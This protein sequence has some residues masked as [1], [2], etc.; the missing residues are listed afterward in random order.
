VCGCIRKCVCVCVCVRESDIMFG[1]CSS[2]VQYQQSIFE[3]KY[4]C[5]F[6]GH[7]ALILHLCVWVY[8]ENGVCVCVCVCVYVCE[9]ERDIFLCMCF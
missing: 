5:F 9:G 2:G 7:A 6:L 8:G 1:P 4:I 3:K